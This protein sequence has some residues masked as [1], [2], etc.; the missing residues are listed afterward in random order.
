MTF[1]T[2]K[3]QALTPYTAGIQPKEPGWVKLNTNENPYPPSSKAAEAIR[4]ANL[5]A[6]RLYPDSDSNILCEVIAGRYGVALENVFCGN[7]SDEVLALAYQAFF[8]ERDNILTPDISYAFY[9]VW[10]QMYGVTAKIIPL[11]EDFSIDPGEYVNSNGV[12]LA[13]PNAPTSRALTL[14]QVETIVRNNPHAVVLIDEAYI[15]FAGV[16]SAVSLV[17]KYENLLVVQTFSK[18]YSLAGL[19]VG[20]AV[21]SRALVDGLQKIKHSFNSYPL[22]MLEQKAATAAMLDTDYWNETRQKVKATRD[23]TIGA[24]RELGYAVQDSHTNFILM[25]A[26]DEGHAKGLYEHLLAHKILARY[27]QKPRISEF[28]RVSVGTDE[29]MEAFLQCVKQF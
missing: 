20:F 12:I 10:A 2:P 27:W 29:E 15:D 11:K 4:G 9:P 21:G 22:G 5:D 19:R 6:L 24:L 16:A 25:K 23:K 13:N 8:A 14:A 1:L 17:P 28:L 7:G 26:K 3:A 18:S